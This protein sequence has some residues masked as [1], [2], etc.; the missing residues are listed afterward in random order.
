MFVFLFYVIVLILIGVSSL[1]Y[2]K[3]LF[4]L[5]TIYFSWEFDKHSALEDL[6][7]SKEERATTQF[8]V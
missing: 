4:T 2:S 6:L 5:Q 7:V 8:L 3:T 1:E